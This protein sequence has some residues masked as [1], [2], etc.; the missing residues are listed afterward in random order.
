MRSFMRITEIA[1]AKIRA[2]ELV[3]N[4]RVALEK[5]KKNLEENPNSLVYK[6]ALSHKKIDYQMNLKMLEG[7]DISINQAIT[8]QAQRHPWLTRLLGQMPPPPPVNH[9]WIDKFTK[10][11]SS[12][13]RGK[14]L[15]WEPQTS[16]NIRKK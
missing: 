9:S 13:K 5:A 1:D 2:K 6:K 14:K 4:S 12:N 8:E 10:T 16:K 15:N 7:L 3:E 11:I